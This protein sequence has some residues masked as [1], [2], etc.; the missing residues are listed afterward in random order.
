MAA[1]NKQKHLSSSFVIEKKHYYSRV[2]HIESNNS[3]QFSKNC[4]VSKTLRTN[5]S[6]LL[7][8]TSLDPSQAAISPH[9]KPAQCIN[10]KIQTSSITKWR[11]L[12]SFNITN[13]QALRDPGK[14]VDIS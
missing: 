10:L 7:L 13:R 12:S 4:S 11:T 3:S 9:V 2:L 5:Y 1:V 6:S 14:E 8:I